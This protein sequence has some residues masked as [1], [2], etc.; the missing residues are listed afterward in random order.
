MEDIV[1]FA[2]FI[3]CVP[4]RPPENGTQTLLLA[5]DGSPHI[6]VLTNK[7]KSDYGEF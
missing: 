7:R 6:H 4:Q 3:F 5:K 2:A 1:H